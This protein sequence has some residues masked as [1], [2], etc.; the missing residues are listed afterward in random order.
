MI[1]KLTALILALLMIISMAGCS[2]IVGEIAGN[3]A[4][5]AK[6]ELE[7]QVK[8]TF[9]KY[10]VDIIEFKSTAGKLSSASGNTQ[11]FCAA[12]IT[13]ESDVLPN[14]IA[15]N[16]SKFFHDAGITVQTGNAIENRYLELK[17]L[18]FKFDGFSD[19]KTYYTVWCYTDKLPSLEDLKNLT[20]AL[21]TEGVG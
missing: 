10:K 14:S 6:K 15:E 2:Q 1:K 8:L 4:E 19:G 16:L 17:D 7:N 21:S 5:A 9:E 13:S 3:V 20:S 18:S 11:F 12:L